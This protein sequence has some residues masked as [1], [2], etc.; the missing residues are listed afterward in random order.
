MFQEY[1]SFEQIRLKIEGKSGSN[2]KE[3]NGIKTESNGN[4][5]QYEKY[6]LHI[7]KASSEKLP[8]K[9]DPLK[10]EV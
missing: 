8:A 10:K 9:I 6:P 5:D 7:L 1:R 2:L 4:F 3:T